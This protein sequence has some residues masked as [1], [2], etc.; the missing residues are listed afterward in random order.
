[1]RFSLVG[2]LLLSVDEISVE[3]NSF[4]FQPRTFSITNLHLNWKSVIRQSKRFQGLGH[5]IRSFR[6]LAIAY[7]WSA[8]PQTAYVVL[9]TSILLLPSTTTIKITSQVDTLHVHT[10]ISGTSAM[11]L[12]DQILTMIYWL[13]LWRG[14]TKCVYYGHVRPTNVG[15]HFCICSVQSMCH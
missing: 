8:S 9:Y 15:Y 10:T 4:L 14:R 7:R 11:L 5:I 2:T 3:L 13:T 6:C 12:S 1:M